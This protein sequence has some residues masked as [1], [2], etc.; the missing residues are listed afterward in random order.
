MPNSVITGVK[1]WRSAAILVPLFR[2]E[3]KSL[4]TDDRDWSGTEDGT[5]KASSFQ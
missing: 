4:A 1:C 2:A 5:V 3:Y